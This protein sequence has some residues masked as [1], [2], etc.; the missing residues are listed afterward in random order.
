MKRES[1][2]TKLFE[3]D[4][5]FSGLVAGI[6]EAGRGPLFGPVAVACC[7]MPM[8][9]MIDGVNDSKKLSEKKREELYDKIV[10]TAISYSV[11]FVSEKRID[12]INIL[13]ATKEGMTETLNNLSV[14]PDVVLVDAVKLNVPSI[15]I[16][17]GDATSYNIACASILAKVS[18]DR[19]ILSIAD[20]YPEYNLAKNK[21]YP[22]KEHTDAIKKYG[23]SVMHRKSFLKNIDKW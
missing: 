20:K 21:G 2:T 13:E 11:V 8:D 3:Y 18:R 14:K 15:P 19:F 12:E 1:K 17:K 4:R 23:P 6:D 7:V 5:N 9:N 10:S 16:I 22:T